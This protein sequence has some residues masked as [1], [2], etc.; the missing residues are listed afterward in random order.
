VYAQRTRADSQ[1]DALRR[2]WNG[3]TEV[4]V[5]STK[6][7]ASTKHGL[8]INNSFVPNALRVES[9]VLLSPP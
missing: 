7:Q 6:R 5:V 1:L 2:E 9:V 4:A 3:V 8:A